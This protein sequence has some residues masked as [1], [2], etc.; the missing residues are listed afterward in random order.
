MQTNSSV[1]QNETLHSHIVNGIS[2]LLQERFYAGNYVTKS[3]L[4]NKGLNE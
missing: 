2:P 1:E 3:Q 4:P